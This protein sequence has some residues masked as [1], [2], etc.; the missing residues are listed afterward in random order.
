MS[1]YLEEGKIDMPSFPATLTFIFHKKHLKFLQCDVSFWTSLLSSGAIAA[2]KSFK[3][4][5]YINLSSFYL[6]LGKVERI[7]IYF[8]WN[9]KL[10]T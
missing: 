8:Y 9:V 5:F 10:Y 3:C 7:D 2:Y 1:S 6:N 4:A